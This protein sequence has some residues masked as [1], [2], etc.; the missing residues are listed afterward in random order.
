MI[1]PLCLL[2]GLWSS[3]KCRAPVSGHAYEEVAHLAN[4]TVH[5]MR[6]ERD[7]TYLVTWERTAQ[8]EYA[9]FDDEKLTREEIA[10]RTAEAF[11]R[12]ADEG[13]Q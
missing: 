7:G 9:P 8:T 6:C 2:Q 5:I 3:L 11:A 10:V 1:H 12:L 4:V 13:R